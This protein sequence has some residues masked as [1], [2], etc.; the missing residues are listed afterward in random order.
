MIPKLQHT[1][2]RASAGSGKTY[3]LANR[4][5]ALLL[6]QSLAAKVAPDKL[7]AVTFTRKGAGEFADRILRRLAKAAGNTKD[8]DELS[9]DLDS[10]VGGNKKEDVV[11]LAPGLR[12][13]MTAE[14]LQSTLAVLVDEFDRLALGTIDSFMARSVQTLAFELGLN[15][16]EILEDAAAERVRRELLTEVFREASRKSLETFYQTVKLATLK[17]ASSLVREVDGFVAAY[18]ELIHELPA[19]EGW[20]GTAFW[21]GPVPVKAAGNW[22]EQADQLLGMVQG[23]SWDSAEVQKAIARAL[24][25]LGRREPGMPASSDPI[26]SWLG[27]KVEKGEEKRGKLLQLWPA[28]PEVWECYPRVNSKK[29]C[30]VPESVMGPLK[31]ILAGWLAAE[32][33]ALAQK[34]RA[35]FDI[36]EEYERLYDLQARRKG[37]LAFND[38]PV[39]LSEQAGTDAEALTKLAFRWFQQFDHW[40]LDEFQ[41]TSRVQWSVLKPWLDECIQDDSGTKSVFVVGDPK[42]SIYGWRGG[43]PRLF[44]ELKGTYPG[45]FNEQIMAQSWRSRP[46]VLELVNQV[47]SPDKNP[48]LNDGNLLP[49]AALRRWKYDLHFSEESR[50]KQPGY[51]AVLLAPEPQSEDAGSSGDDAGAIGQATE[52][53]AAQARVIK[54]VLDKVQPLKKGLSCA[55]LVRKNANAQSIAQWLRANGVANVMVEGDAR[56][57]DQAPVVAAFVD[58]LR[59]LHTPAHTLAAGHVRATPLWDVLARRLEEYSRASDKPGRDAFHCVPDQLAGRQIGTQ[60]NASLPTGECAKQLAGG[61]AAPPAPGAV[62]RYWRTRLSEIGAG[63][64][65]RE[66]CRELSPLARDAYSQ[67]C[68]RQVDQLASHQGSRLALPDWLM[69][70]EELLVRET[71]AAGSIHIMTIHKAK[72]LGFDVVL[73]PDLDLGGGTPDEVLIRRDTLGRAAGCLVNPPKWLRAWVPELEA[74]SAAQEAEKDLEALCVLYVALTRA[75]EA[76]FV[77]LRKEKPRAASRAREWLLG[78]VGAATANTATQAKPSDWGEGELI[79]EEG[80]SNIQADKAGVAQDQA[81]PPSDVKLQPPVQRPTRRRPSD[82][83]H[84]AWVAEAKELGEAD[85]RGQE[86]GTAVHAVFEQIEWWQ[87]SQRLSGPTDAI[88]A[89]RKCMDVPDILALFT[90][91]VAPDEAYREL[92]VELLEQEVWW[93]GMLDRLVLRRRADGS[94]AS[95]VLIDFKTDAV[96]T[97]DKLRERY[98]E[99]LAVYSRAVATALKIS[100]ASVETVLVSTHLRVALRLHLG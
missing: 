36:V 64:A 90:Q 35:I 91:N 55:I 40:L 89:V 14:A 52:R 93:S 57:A 15:G 66:W 54:S 25:W 59:W 4:Y 45:A 33:Q 28:W 83:G 65:T 7:V 42:Q 76:T 81:L 16:F 17:S 49:A 27:V 88:A 5:I 96:N 19:S 95:A 24:E 60:W 18:H 62:W 46:A 77:I 68:L 26:P 73:L 20:G 21:N 94:L 98:A 69:T 85:R 56:L 44:E 13:K 37:R 70:L 97:A 12:L 58:A 30:M 9:E 79:W 3:Q 74:L 61:E 43:E 1:I 86:F 51:A 2:I 80:V 34:T 50:D 75:K 23:R 47:C 78:G 48:A 71:A 38:M 41:D 87:P 31:V 99:Q 10:L 92:P 22:R 82:A 11:G 67:Y 29:P 84:T 72:G 6:L 100:E 39:L 8:R 32:N 53:L 63:E